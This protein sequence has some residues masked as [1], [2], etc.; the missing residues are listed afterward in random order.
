MR[1]QNALLIAASY[2]FYGW[3]DWRFL[4]LIA[5]SSATD[6]LVGLALERARR[7]RPRRLLLA[8]S[9]GVNLGLLGT[10]KYF[11]FFADSLVAAFESLG[12]SLRPLT[13]QLVLPVGISFYTFQTLSYTIDLYRRRIRVERDPLAFFA[14]VSFFPQLV[15]G[16]IERAARMLPQFDRTRTLNYDEAADALRRIAWGVFKKVVVADTCARLVDAVY[17]HPARLDGSTELLAA[18]LFAFQIYCDFSAYSDIAMGTAKLFGFDLM[19]NF[20]TPYFSRSIAEFWRRWHISLSTWFRDYVFIP[21]GGSRAAA[22]RWALNILITFTASGLW[23]GANWTFVVWG[24]LHAL[25][26]LPRLVWPRRAP[27]ESGVVA[28]GSL[29]PSPREFL[30]IASTF[31][32]TT[33]AW[34]FFRSASVPEA[35]ARLGRILSPSLLS[36]PFVQVRALGLAE[37]AA[38]ACGAILLLV[39]IEWIQRERPHPLAVEP[40]PALLRWSGYTALLGVIALF[41]RTGD[42]LDFIYFQF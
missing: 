13:L 25:Y 5:L 20:A 27:V 37:P 30:Q 39:V 6:F 3:W 28:A 26:Y 34:V 41:R 10:F 21:L 32:L 11:G 8:A 2:V 22:P 1:G 38:I 42:S 14:F 40:F 33:L 23:H 31:S 17:S 4:G 7:E 9:L 15:A 18:V 29:L 19:N 36:N 12:V 16:P 35:V 24:L